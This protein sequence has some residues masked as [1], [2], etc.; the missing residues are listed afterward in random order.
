MLLPFALL[1]IA[2][3]ILRFADVGRPTL[4]ADPFIGFSDVHPLF[5]VDADRGLYRVA[6]S[7]RKFFAFEAFP[8]EKPPRT[9][10]VFCLGGS[11]VKGEPYS[12]PTS[13]TAWLE[14][15]LNAC[16]ADHDWDIV[17]C[18]GISYASY[19]LI[20]ILEEC[21]DYQPD[22][23]VICSGHNEF[24]ED[25]T[26]GHLK[27]PDSVLLAS[28]RA[29]LSSRLVT[30]AR[31]TIDTFAGQNELETV[32]NRPV[33]GPETDPILDYNDSLKA[34][35]WDP[36]WRRGVVAHYEFN[37]RRMLDLAEEAGVSVIF[38]Q[39]P[40]NLGGF[41]PLKSDHHPPLSDADA[42]RF[43]E[44]TTAA[45]E[46]YSDELPHAI[47]LLQ[48]AV[49]ISPGHAATWYD[50]GQC[51]IAAG[52]NDEARDCLVRARDND[53]VPLRMISDLEAAMQRVARERDI[54]LINAHSL[55]ESQTPHEILDDSLL[56]DHIHPGFDGHQSIAR[57]L[58]RILVDQDEV[59]LPEDWESRTES[60]WRKHFE[61]LDYPYFASGQRFL[62]SLE[63][64]TQGRGDGPPAAERFPWR[65]RSGD[66]GI[67]SD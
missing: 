45:R 36:E 56:V 21:L 49:E 20:P 7:R 34:Y 35:H 28:Q 29:V 3:A 55:L 32:E 12:I 43:I 27:D 66:G 63:G 53:L 64:W 51:L 65:I 48:Q 44:L 1:L 39:P 42:N 46:N 16:D 14:L 41:P 11:T 54:P 52:R 26:Y 47:K 50:L 6:P 17:N 58:V 19:R 4:A 8:T 24:L 60:V 31:Q 9:R 5:E 38:I 40:S 37:L 57:A 30:L 10:R 18:G 23:F 15:A 62:K 67:T 22:L 33:L 61:S 2:E 59:T 25:R 13:F